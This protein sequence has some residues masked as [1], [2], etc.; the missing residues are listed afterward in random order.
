MATKVEKMPNQ[1]EK[2]PQKKFKVSVLR[3]HCIKLFGVSTSTFDGAM[4]RHKDKELTVEEADAI[5][6]K[7]LKG[8]K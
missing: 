6:K 8:G 5:I 7:W 1:E 3:K 2:I 4:R